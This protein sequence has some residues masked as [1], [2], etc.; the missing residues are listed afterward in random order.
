VK[1]SDI[2]L[3]LLAVLDAILQ[4]RSVGRAAERVGL[5]KP[6][7]S[8]ALARLR[9]QIGDPVLV[10]AGKEW[11]LSERALGM[12]DR[13][14]ELAEGAR[15]VLDREPVFDPKTSDRE[16]TLHCTD[17]VL[18]LL[19]TEIGHTVGAEAPGVSLRFLP[20]QP[21][22]VSPLRAGD[23]DLALGVF[24]DLP[25]ELRTQALF[26]ERFATV[27]RRGHPHVD[28]KLTMK[29]FLSLKHVLVA[30]RGR[31]GGPVD[32]ALAERGQKR[33]VAR[34]VP[35]FVVAL[36]LVS[37]SDCAVTISERLAQRY[38]ERFELQV[39]RPPF[40]LPSYTIS[41]VW[42]PRVDRSPAHAWLR[43]LVV[44]AVAAVTEPRARGAARAPHAA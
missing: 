37:R 1:A 4:T 19:G 23:V 8:H 5:S 24:P 28:G 26:H 22:D 18:A 38:A 6:A 35:Y 27:V 7:M 36:D 14:H 34:Q 29:C 39:L 41:Q 32:A 21:D 16:F 2:D 12:C 42:H 11:Q 43:Q 25:P 10:R 9:L 40:P 3:N 30:P 44:R 13:V 20:I 17:H 33:R 31:A 15:S